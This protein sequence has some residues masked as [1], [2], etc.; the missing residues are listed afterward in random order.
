MKKIRFFL[1]KTVAFFNRAIKD[2]IG[3]FAAQ[4]SFF[5]IFSLVPILMLIITAVRFVVPINVS[6]ALKSLHTYLPVQMYS[7]VSDIVMDVYNKS[8]STGI[9]SVSAVSALWLASKGIMAMYQ[10]L[11]MIFSPEYRPNYFR[12]R[13]ISVLYTALFVAAMCMTII[14][15]G[16]GNSIADLI[17]EHMKFMVYISKIVLQWK[18]IVFPMLSMIFALFYKLLPKEKSSFVKQLPGAVLAAMGWIIFS[19]IYSVYVEYFSNYSYVYG[20]LA[21][22]VLLMLWLYICMYIFLLGA[23]FNHLREEKFFKVK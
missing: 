11:N 19:Y 5:I 4:A 14:L 22:I 21:A 20:S 6:A 18:I 8:A 2:N 17:P 23:E 16:F 10:G 3:V 7:F 12:A 1:Q 15:F 9:I 13:G